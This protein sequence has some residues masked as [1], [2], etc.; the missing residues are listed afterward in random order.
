[1][2]NSKPSYYGVL[3]AQVRYDNAL[4]NLAKLLYCEISAL[5]TKD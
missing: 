5:A 3:P 4:T 1:M 2:M